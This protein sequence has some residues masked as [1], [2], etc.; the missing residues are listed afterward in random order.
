LTETCQFCR[1]GYTCYEHT[2]GSEN[3][4]ITKLPREAPAPLPEYLE[5]RG[6]SK[7]NRESIKRQLVTLGVE[8]AAA[9]RSKS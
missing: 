6:P 1:P 8:D 5:N 7:Q 3:V 4:T 2:V 9:Q